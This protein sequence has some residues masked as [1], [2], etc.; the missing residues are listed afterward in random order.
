MS[1]IWIH[2]NPNEINQKAQSKSENRTL[3][4]INT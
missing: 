1:L 2:A 4:L 3:A